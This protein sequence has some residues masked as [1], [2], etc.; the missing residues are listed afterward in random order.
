MAVIVVASP[1]GGVGKT[2]VTVMLAEE[3]AQR[4]YLVGVVEADKARHIAKYLA[5]RSV[6]NR[7]TEDG[8]GIEQAND[9]FTLYT[10]EDPTTLGSTIKQADQE[11]DIVVVDLPGF[12]GLEFTRAVARANLVLIPMRPSVMDHSGAQIAMQT[13]AIEEDHLDRKIDFRLLLNMVQDAKNRE[14]ARGLSK[15][16]AELRRHIHE[17]NF[18]RLKS[19]LTMRRSA[20]PGAYSYAMSPREYA[21]EINTKSA[22][23]A[24]AE[25]SALASEVLRI[26]LDGG[27]STDTEEAEAKRQKKLEGEHA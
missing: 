1:K 23:D 18:P 20:I 25:V 4:D 12:E 11:N 2:T 26:L 8:E 19:E 16:E 14:H 6:R 27:F 24:L 9:N 10:D 22:H 3:L 21:E 7:E 5:G 17:A 13:I 15:T